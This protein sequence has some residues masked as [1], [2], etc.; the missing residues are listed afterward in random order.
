MECV[1]LLCLTAA[2]ALVAASAEASDPADAQSPQA[3]IETRQ[4]GFKKMG[5]AMKAIVEQ[6]K[7]D[8]PDKAKMAAAAQ[9]ISAGAEAQVRWFPAG[10]GAEAGVD[11]D[12]LPNIW[13]D[14]EKFDSLSTKLIPE[15]RNLAA[16]MAGTDL[17]AIRMQ[18]K[19]VADV[20]SSC[21]RSYRAD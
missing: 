13:K 20:C 7:S 3:I 15:T 16:A 12:A 1:A 5:G 2:G 10:S 18:V 9:V 4:A 6:L 19:A 21:H 8:S 14:R 11:T 17:A